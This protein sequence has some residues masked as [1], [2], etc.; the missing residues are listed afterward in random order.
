MND[1]SIDSGSFASTHQTEDDAECADVNNGDFGTVMASV[2]MP[3]TSAAVVSGDLHA[4]S[5]EVVDLVYTQAFSNCETTEA[6]ICEAFSGILLR[7]WDLCCIIAFLQREDGQFGESYIH[8]NPRLDV[9]K[10]RRAGASL[11]AMVEHTGHEQLVW[12]DHGRQS[13]ASETAQRESATA[14]STKPGP[15]KLKP[16]QVEPTKMESP[17]RAGQ[18]VDMKHVEIQQAYT[19]AGLAG[20]LAVPIR[21]R[22]V[23]VGVIVAVASDVEQLRVALR[24]IRFIA[25]P[26]VIAI[27][28][29]RRASAMNEQR[30][31][32]ERLVDELQLRR[33][34]LEEANVELQRIGRY[35]S[36][37]L[38]RMSHEL[39]TPLT[40]ILGFAEIL[41]DHENLTDTQH[42]FCERIQASGLQL[43]ASLT[44]LVDLSRLEAGHAEIF[45]H[46]FVVREMLRESCAAVGRLAHKQGVKI[47]CCTD[48]QLGAIVSDEGKLRQVL[49][50]FLAHAISRSPE[51]GY[52]NVR[53]ECVSPARFSITITDEGMPLLDPTYI[54]EPV[55]LDANEHGATMNELGLVIAHRLVTVLGGVVTLDTDAPHGLTVRLEMPSRPG[56]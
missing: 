17:G 54:F 50:N 28:N 1:N 46:E 35:R 2:T 45:L 43:Q 34:A 18:V 36:L 7:H 56:E 49:Y 37:F 31:H 53:A 15:V 26:I 4:L 11:A 41:L 10:A 44:H 12:L 6:S 51:G 52:V 42:R 22:G 23:L 21:A 13:R 33:A 55:N 40:S 9:A 32:I 29:A 19:D 48:P 38:A 5:A 24:G 25:A 47:E 27:G 30:R 20:G 39:R 8:T 16:S 3:A 14:E